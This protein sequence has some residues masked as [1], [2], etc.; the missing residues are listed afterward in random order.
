MSETNI[1]I[2]LTGEWTIHNLPD[3][4]TIDTFTPTPIQTSGNTYVPTISPS[5]NFTPNTPNSVN[6]NGDNT[7]SPEKLKINILVLLNK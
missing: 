5:F 4:T 1:N 3:I 7:K 6:N 2:S